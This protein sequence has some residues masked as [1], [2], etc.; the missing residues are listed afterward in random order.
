MK[1]NIIIRSII[2]FNL[3]CFASIKLLP[4]ISTTFHNQISQMALTEGS[5]VKIGNNELINGW[6][7]FSFVIDT[8]VSGEDFDYENDITDTTTEDSEIESTFIFPDFKLLTQQEM[9]EIFALFAAGF[10]VE[11]G[12]YIY[13]EWPAE[14]ACPFSLNGGTMALG[15]DLSLSSA[16][17][18]VSPGGGGKISG[19]G[20]AIRFKGNFEI[21]E[22]EYFHFISD[23]ILEGL[24]HE[25]IL[26][27]NAQLIV[28][29]NTTLSLRNIIL[30]CVGDTPEL[31]SIVMTD[32]SSKLSLQNVIISLS[33]DYTFTQGSM[34]ID[35]D[36]LIT[37]TSTFIY[38]SNEPIFI[39]DSSTLYFDLGSTFSYA[40]SNAV[41]GSNS[42][43]INM[44]NIT[45]RLSLD[46][47]TL[48]IP[49]SGLNLTKGTLIIT[50][51]V[52]I[53]N[54]GGTGA[55]DCLK[56]GDGTNSENDLNIE[57]DSRG[58]LNFLSGTL[59]YSNVN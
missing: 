21:P 5:L 30:K 44:K 1:Q 19:N 57:I 14:V 25:L 36:V 59:D 10:E 55:G 54:D 4:E 17:N 22:G 34:F 2:L 16:S 38:T 45:S 52:D 6:S 31:P 48:N 35:G 7:D 28:D 50:G 32:A 37:G 39:S 42:A 9:I 29:M 46:T 53:H 41:V 56:F 33:S 13:I 20:N 24:G 43:L 3:T 58:S 11:I 40:P 12:G 49:T 18:L 23:T 8:G 47:C 51:K 15:I 26:T 27:K